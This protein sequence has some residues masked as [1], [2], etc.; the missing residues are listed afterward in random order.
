MSTKG[1]ISKTCVPYP[2]IKGKVAI[3]TG[4]AG[5]IGAAISKALLNA[6]GKVA[7]VGRHP[8]TLRKTAANLDRGK[9]R[10][11]AVRADVRS[12]AEVRRMVRVVLRRF[13]K[14]D[15][16]VNNAGARGPTVPVTELRLADWQQVFDTNL[17][18][19]FLCARECLK[20][21]AER[22]EGRIINISS[23]VARMAYPLRASYSASKSGLVNLTMTLAQEMGPWNIQVNAILPGPVAVPALEEVIQ[24]RAKTLGV[25]VEEA[26]RRFMRPSALG[27][28]VTPEEIGSLVLFLS[29]DGARNI[30][31]QAIDIGG[32]G[33]YPG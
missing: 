12:E 24:D 25:D 11:V 13:G 8:A 33:L 9:D 17:T 7:L 4:A 22:R 10:T 30:T 23:V 19:A 31:G 5:G 16:L 6:G 14:I 20:H 18:G 32:Y 21:L 3:V 27:R 28:L 2:E 15:I 1:Q 26:R 29:S